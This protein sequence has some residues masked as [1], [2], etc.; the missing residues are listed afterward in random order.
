MKYM[1]VTL[2]LVIT[3]LVFAA[4]I[5][6]NLGASATKNIEQTA[7]FEN[8]YVSEGLVAMYDGEWNAGWGKHKNA[9]LP[10]NLVNGKDDLLLLQGRYT[11][12]DK[13]YYKE[14][15]S[16]GIFGIPKAYEQYLVNGYTIQVVG[17]HISGGAYPTI[18]ANYD[19]S[20]QIGLTPKYN[21][22]G[23]GYTYKYAANV[24]SSFSL[25][26][27]IDRQELIEN[28]VLKATWGNWFILDSNK[29]WTLGIG[30]SAGVNS[31][32]D[33]SRIYCIRLYNRVLTDEEVAM[34][35]LV[36]VER[37]GNVE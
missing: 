1:I 2:S 18:M 8:P 24:L 3:A 12:F 32:W 22:V 29:A 31:T 16:C 26:C 5:R 33:T 11:V 30:G 7:P 17:M 15:N 9:G 10:I 34:N 6:S 19:N 4:P 13:Y 37:F 35:Y 25:T 23:K 28:G 20:T 21:A 36:D 14:R 27:G